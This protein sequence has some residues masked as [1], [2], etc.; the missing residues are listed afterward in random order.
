MPD[1]VTIPFSH[2][3][4]KARWALD[5][6]GIPRRERAALPGLHLWLTRGRGARST[7]HLELD[8]GRRLTDSSDILAW[9]EAQRPGS[10]LP[11]DSAARREVLELE[12]LFDT[13]I[14]PHSRRLAYRAIFEDGGFLAPLFQECSAG[15]QRRV[16]PAVALAMRPIIARSYSIDVRG[17]TRSHDV[18]SSALDAVDARLAEGRRFLVADRFTA[19][20]LTFAAL[21]A[22]I[23]MP[24]EQPVTGP[25]AERAAGSTAL[26]ALK[27]RYLGRPSVTFAGRLYREERHG[28]PARA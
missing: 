23:T 13:R 5:R 12:E 26:T 9:A 18:L 20:D 8:D 28:R 25:L 2:Y 14:G 6:A 7:P 11:E 24:I 27:G 1:L 16:A 4:E 15:W 22:P 3:C 10:L 19:A 21:L 17:A